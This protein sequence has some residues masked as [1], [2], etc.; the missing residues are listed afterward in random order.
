M[1]DPST[2][3]AGEVSAAPQRERLADTRSSLTHK[4]RVGEDEG[5]LTVG[6][7]PDGRPAELF[8]KIAKHGSTISGL[9]DT[10]AVLTSM[11]LQYSVPVQTL[12]CK[13]EYVRFEPSGWTDH[14]EIR[15]AHSLVDYIFRWLGSE[16][17]NVVKSD[18]KASSAE[19]SNESSDKPAAASSQAAS[20]E[21]HDG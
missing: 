13:F 10:I 11:A 8:I 20:V 4:F 18:L 17:G 5:Y 9:V 19:A 3:A 21:S 12:A 2:P 14:P 16:F 1:S 6:L 7:Y 15:Q